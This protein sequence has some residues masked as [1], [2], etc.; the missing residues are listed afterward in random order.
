MSLDKSSCVF[1]LKN[2][3]K[4]TKWLLKLDKECQKYEFK[5]RNNLN[6]YGLN[7]ISYEY[8]EI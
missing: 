6:K 1:V 7:P 4:W 8:T 5:N 2:G 3:E